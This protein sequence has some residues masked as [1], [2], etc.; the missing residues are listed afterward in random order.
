MKSQTTITVKVVLELDDEE[1]RWLKS[2]MQNPLHN[3]DAYSEREQD[4]EMRRKFF[5]AISI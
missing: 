5:D 1:A 4:K 2:V 3:Q